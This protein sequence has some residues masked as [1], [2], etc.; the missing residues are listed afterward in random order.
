MLLEGTKLRFEK[1]DG[2]IDVRI[3]DQNNDSVARYDN[4]YH[5]WVIE[6][7]LF[8]DHKDIT[9]DDIPYNLRS[10]KTV[11]SNQQLQYMCDYIRPTYFGTQTFGSPTQNGW[12]LMEARRTTAIAQDTF[13]K[14]PKEVKEILDKISKPVTPEMVEMCKALTGFNH[15]NYDH[16]VLLTFGKIERIPELEKSFDLTKDGREEMN[17]SADDRDEI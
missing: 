12:S 8:H 2:I 14:L 11:I 10:G 1:G 15:I 16:A 3:V 9:P 5:V 13:E 17:I 4:S 7:S 6:D